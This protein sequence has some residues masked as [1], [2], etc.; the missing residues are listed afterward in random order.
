MGKVDELRADLEEANA[1]TNEIADDVDVLVA[2]ALA[3]GL[4]PEE[5]DEIQTK[6][7]ALKARLKDVAAKYTPGAP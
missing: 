7:A 3:G 4:T 1:T 5:T 6:V 2:K